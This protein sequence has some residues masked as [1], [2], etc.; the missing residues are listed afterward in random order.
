MYVY[1]FQ[2][3]ESADLGPTTTNCAA[4]IRIMT[5]L[6][7]DVSTI[8]LISIFVFI[9]NLWKIKQSSIIISSFLHFLVVSSF[10]SWL[11]PPVYHPRPRCYL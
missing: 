4:S 6:M 8:Y 7:P 2:Q 10:S 3:T 9:I 5:T 11:R 1:L